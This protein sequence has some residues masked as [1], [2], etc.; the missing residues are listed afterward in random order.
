MW[1]VHL[2][3]F[4]RC[5]IVGWVSLF[6]FAATEVQLGAGS[7]SSFRRIGHWQVLKG[8]GD[9]LLYQII[10]PS[11]T[12]KRDD[13]D[14]HAADDLQDGHSWIDATW[15]CLRRPSGTCCKEA[16]ERLSSMWWWAHAQTEQGGHGSRQDQVGGEWPETC[17]ISEQQSHSK[18]KVL[19]G[20]VSA[21][22]TMFLYIQF[23]YNVTKLTC[24]GMPLG[25][26][27]PV[28]EEGS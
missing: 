16:A 5:R 15:W 8:R 25:W 10:H 22:Q 7:E 19:S 9:Q 4:R 18:L 1:A 13:E 2:D 23:S 20:N 17:C 21:I 28:L 11:F 26:L 3:T 12:F 6:A 27:R 14:Y 24:P